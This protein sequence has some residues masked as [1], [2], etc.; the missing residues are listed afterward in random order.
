M[1]Q[2]SIEKKKD[3]VNMYINGASS[4]EIASGADIPA[5]EV[6]TIISDFK[7]SAKRLYELAQKTDKTFEGIATEIE[8]LSQEHEKLASDLTLMETM[9]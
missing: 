4:D 1:T 2:L 6:D 8:Q 3:V 5:N 9:D 7:G